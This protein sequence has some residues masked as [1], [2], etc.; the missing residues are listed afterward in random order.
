M[1]TSTRYSSTEPDEAAAADQAEINSL[2][3]GHQD[4]DDERDL[5]RILRHIRDTL[6][7]A[8]TD[9]AELLNRSRP[10]NDHP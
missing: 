3:V 4:S 2:D 6:A 10:P 5:T 8:R 9:I 7:D 1:G